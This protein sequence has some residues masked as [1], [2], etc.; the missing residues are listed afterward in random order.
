[1]TDRI[2]HR[3][4][5]LALALI[6]I[7]VFFVD[8]EIRGYLR[9]RDSASTNQRL[10]ST[11]QLLATQIA[12]LPVTTFQPW[13]ESTARITGLRIT[14]IEP[15][16]R[17]VADSTRDEAS[18]ENQLRRPEVTD[19][20]QKNSGA[21]VDSGIAYYALS[22]TGRPTGALILKLSVPLAADPAAREL[23]A[24]V[25]SLSVGSAVLALA[26][27]FLISRS[28]SRRVGRL[29][30]IAAGMLDS[31]QQDVSVEYAGDDL[32]SLERSLAGVAR[33][34][35]GL[36]ERLGFESARREAI[37]S[38]MAE[39]VLAVDR[40]LRVTF[41][42]E[43]FQKAIGPRTGSVVGL[44]LL[45][46]V[47]DPQL[48]DL[49]ISVI[50][51]GTPRQMRLKL[52]V[53]NPRVF[54]VQSTPL[55]TPAGLGAIAIFHDTTELERLEQVRK[56][57]VANV[58]HE[59][60]TPLA[61]IIGYAETL[62]DGGLNDAANKERFVEIIRKNAIRLNSIAA[63][64]LVLSELEAGGDAVEPDIISVPAVL[65]ATLQIVESEARS[66]DVRL[67]REEVDDVCVQG[68]RLRLEQV[69][70]NLVA[71]AIKFNRPGGE[72]RL[73]AKE[74][75]DGR[76]S[77]IISDTGVGIPSQDLPRI[78]ERFYR[79]DKAR[80]KEVGGTGLG[81]SIVKHA[82]ERM[83]GSIAVES[84]LGRGSRFT[85][86]LPSASSAVHQN[87]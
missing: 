51:T 25:F 80:S 65:D 50:A 5:F 7:T 52:S 62:L 2:F 23:R 47:R 17:V 87:V 86:F 36:L 74:M 55:A 82:I 68:S 31:A 38:G 8:S 33:E 28:L 58:S 4:L 15:S 18:N 45:E 59:L 13:V 30:R 20:L 26:V 40:D 19:A 37:L 84:E 76:V 56:D 22:I 34:L 6:A 9:D 60:R 72:V 14:L 48:R 29:K 78:F 32:A 64:L 41:C 71:N 44:V 1:M 46:L 57:F 69:V 70:L 12:A 10:T 24:R 16:G 3:L 67:V 11:G 27:A 54:A 81:L 49:L 53:E 73:S 75:D 83:N 21:A 35:R 42:N 85:L 63:D 61:G 79:V 39:G 43:A 77:I 66:R